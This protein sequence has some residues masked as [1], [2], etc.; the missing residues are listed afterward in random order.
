MRSVIV[1]TD[2]YSDPGDAGGLALACAAHRLG[3]INL[4]GVNCCTS[5]NQTAQ[6]ISALCNWW[7]V[8]PTV[9]TWKGSAGQTIDDY[10]FPPNGGWS[11]YLANNFAPYVGVQST[12]QESVAF[13]RTLL[14]N[15]P[16]KV[17]IV[18]IGYLQA[19]NA[20]LISGADSISPL[21]GSALIAA[22]VNRFYVDA[23]GYPGPYSEWNFNGG[24]GSGSYV[25]NQLYFCGASS[26]FVAN[27]PVPIT[28]TGF[29]LGT[30]NLCA[31]AGKAT[32]DLMYQAYH[33]AGYDTGRPCWDEMGVYACITEC[34][35]FSV[36]QGT[37]SVSSAA[38]ATNTFTASA[39]GPHRYV[40]KSVGDPILQSR[41]TAMQ[42]AVVTNSPLMASWGGTPG[43]VKVID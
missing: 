10:T 32:S 17:D 23:G 25:A 14:A 37:N 39:T 18:T 42:T 38:G 8:R 6:G 30:F 9:G 15:S 12:V 35:D 40:V 3:W 24:S 43:I 28:F 33:Q 1:D 26:N 2:F 34:A 27:C 41:I 11:Q 13:Y 16:V 31:T 29:E 36:V 7:G 19:V 22:K 21:T 5:G 4:I 20:L